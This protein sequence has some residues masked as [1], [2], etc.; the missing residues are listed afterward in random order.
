MPLLGT[1]RDNRA[2]NAILGRKV[3]NP[4]N[5]HNAS[6]CLDPKGETWSDVGL[7]AEEA[8]EQQPGIPGCLY[9]QP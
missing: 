9:H 7:R 1:E 2:S 5:W 4:A 8:P 6:V 3:Q